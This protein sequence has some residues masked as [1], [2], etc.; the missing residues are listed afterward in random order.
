M[1]QVKKKNGMPFW[2]LWVW[3]QSFPPTSTWNSHSLG[4]SPEISIIA[5]KWMSGRYLGS[6]PVDPRIPVTNGGFFA[7]Q[8][9]DPFQMFQPSGDKKIRI[10]RPGGFFFLTKLCPIWLSKTTTLCFFDGL[11]WEPTCLKKRQAI[12]P[13][14]ANQLEERQDQNHQN[15][16]QGP[17]TK[18]KNSGVKCKSPFSKKKCMNELNNWM[19]L[20][21]LIP[22]M[23][24]Y[25]NIVLKQNFVSLWL[26]VPDYQPGG[27]S[28]L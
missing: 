12:W 15:D 2:H 20:N 24:K 17:Q 28:T 27:I 8:F 13:L 7:W 23:L 22:N 3:H 21:L 9:V 19:I 26:V 4:R 6:T 11:K 5:K 1:V 18:K 16:Q 25:T 10:L 14:R